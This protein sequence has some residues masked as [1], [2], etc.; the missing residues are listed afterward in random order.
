[1]IARILET[2]RVNALAVRNLGFLNAMHLKYRWY[3]VRRSGSTE[4]MTLRSK[5]AAYPLWCRP[6]TTDSKVFYQIFILRE[7]A[8]LDDVRNPALI[9]DCGA[10]V[11]YSSAYFLSRFP[12]AKLIAVEPDAENAK[13]LDRNLRPFGDRATI[14]RSAVWSHAAGLVIDQ[15]AGEGAWAIRARECLPGEPASFHGT[16]VGALLEESGERS[17]SLLKMDI[18]GA[19]AVVFSRDFQGWLSRT[20]AIVIELHGEENRR[21]FASVMAEQPFAISRHSELT[22]CKRLP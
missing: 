12:E 22:V 4:P 8:C 2:I 7:Y 9:I 5:H 17:I 15:G 19:E 10:N 16:T 6:G 13:V 21:L 3:C 18:E 11:G 1:V 14:V 20:E